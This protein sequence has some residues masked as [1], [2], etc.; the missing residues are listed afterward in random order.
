VVIP[1]VQYLYLILNLQAER[2][3]SKFYLLLD[4]TNAVLQETQIAVFESGLEVLQFLGNDLD[5]GFQQFAE[6]SDFSR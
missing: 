4:T 2:T 6:M 3:G 1:L 5:L